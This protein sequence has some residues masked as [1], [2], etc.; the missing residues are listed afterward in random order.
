MGA[1]GTPYQVSA[2]AICHFHASLRSVPCVAGFER[3]Q[4]AVGH[5]GRGQPARLKCLSCAHSQGS[6]TGLPPPPLDLP[7]WVLAFPPW[8]LAAW[9]VSPGLYVG[10]F[11]PFTSE[12]VQLQRRFGRWEDEEEE[13]GEAQ[14][15][16]PGDAG[17]GIE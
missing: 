8:L 5:Q 3:I 15:R 13:E 2:T 17:W 12:V 9:P 11:G 4:T 6:S 16:S 1:L 7:L 10:A 14:D